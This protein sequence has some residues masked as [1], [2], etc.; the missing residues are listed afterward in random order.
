M[1]VPAPTT[2]VA[3]RV[4]AAALVLAPKKSVAV[5]IFAAAPTRALVQIRYFQSFQ[6]QLLARRGVVVQSVNQ[7]SRS[8][9][10]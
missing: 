8:V 10:E 6:E 3:V 9:D 7:E 1:D 4:D 5:Q 2:Q